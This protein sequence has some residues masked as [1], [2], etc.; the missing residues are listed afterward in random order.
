MET[1][2]KRGRQRFTVSGDAVP[3]LRPTVE[4]VLAGLPAARPRHL[5]TKDE[6]PAILA[7][8]T[9]ELA[10]LRRNIEQAYLDGL[11]ERPMFHTDA[12]ALPY[13]EYFG[14]FRDFCD[15]NLVA[16]ALGYHLL[17]D[18]TAGAFAKKLFLHLCDW[19][20]SGPCSLC[21][22][23]GDEVGL[24]MARCLPAVFDL[25]YPLMN[26]K[27]RRYAGETVAMY[28]EQCERR[29][30]ALNYSHNPGSSH[31]GRLPAY[32]GE[33]ALTLW[34]TGIVPETTLRGWLNKALTI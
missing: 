14:R 2:V 16:C 33:A 18:E 6:I 4:Q 19:N 15:R 12:A 1:G 7:S 29:I 31:V 10:T 9:E 13:R 30:S 17:N 22:P 20:P 34:G 32:L 28:A 24:S 23:W 25:L 11:P 27:E 5:F 26:D 21:G 8:R 3:F